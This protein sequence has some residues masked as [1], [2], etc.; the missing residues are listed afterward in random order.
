MSPGSSAEDR[1]VSLAPRNKTSRNP[2]L[3]LSACN[4][5]NVPSVI[6]VIGLPSRPEFCRQFERDQ[7]RYQVQLALEP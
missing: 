3:E 4:I 1:T 5:G 6:K 7:T 2:P